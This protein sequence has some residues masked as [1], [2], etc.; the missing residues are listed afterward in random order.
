MFCKVVGLAR[1]IDR[2]N[3]LKEQ[4]KNESGKFYPL[5]CDMTKEE[6]ILASFDWI[7]NNVGNIDLLVNNAG[8]G[9]LTTLSGDLQYLFL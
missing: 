9:R 3:N 5:K 1:R 2:L 6:E 4:L 8:F 7:K